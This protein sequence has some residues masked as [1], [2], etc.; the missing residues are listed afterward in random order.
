VFDTA[1][2]VCPRDLD[3]EKKEQGYSLIL[4]FRQPTPESLATQ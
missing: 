3:L 1:I 4:S 2:F